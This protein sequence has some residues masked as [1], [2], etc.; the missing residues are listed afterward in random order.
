MYCARR[1]LRNPPNLCE[2]FKQLGG[3]LKAP[4]TRVKAWSQRSETYTYIIGDM[5]RAMLK[6]ANR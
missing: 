2:R 5:N 4:C 1:H 3:E 6:E